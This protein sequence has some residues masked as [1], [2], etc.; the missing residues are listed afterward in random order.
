MLADH[1]AGARALERRADEQRALDRR[2]NYD[3]FSTDLLIPR[4]ASE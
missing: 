2:L 3:R 1:A 4:P